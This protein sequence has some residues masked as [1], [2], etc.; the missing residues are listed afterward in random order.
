MRESRPTK[1]GTRRED[2]ESGKWVGSDHWTS[3]F[4]F[5]SDVVSRF[6]FQKEAIFHDVTLRDGEQTPGVVLRRVE[7]VAIARKLDEVG[8]HRFEPGMPGVAQGDLAPA[9]E[10]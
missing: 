3:R 2:S 5:D 7:K 1:A 8:V 6:E 10:R 4:N 9:K